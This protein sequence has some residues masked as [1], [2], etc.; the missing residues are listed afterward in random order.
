MK[1]NREQRE[2]KKQ[3]SMF[4]QDALWAQKNKD[5]WVIDCGWSSHMTGD[6]TNF[7]TL[8]KNEGSATFEDNGSSTIIGKGTL[9]IENGRAKVE[10]NPCIEKL[11]HNLL[12]VRQM[13]DLGHN[14]TF[15]SQECE[16]GK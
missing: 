2:Q 3:K 14:L 10:K 12:S 11:K 8:K 4:V 7:I 16:I 15:N 13:F 9:S 5:K 6:K 1:R